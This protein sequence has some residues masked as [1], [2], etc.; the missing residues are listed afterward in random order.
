MVSWLKYSLNLLL[1]IGLLGACEQ[2]EDIKQS[3]DENLLNLQRK[4]YYQ[5]SKKRQVNSDQLIAINPNES[6]YYQ[7]KSMAHTKIGDYH[8]AF[9]LLEKAWDLD[10]KETGYYYG[11]LL[12][13]Y[14][15]DYERALDKLETYDNFTPDSPDFCWG[16]HINYLKGLCH[17]QMGNY[18][19]AISEFDRLIAYEGEFVDVY[20]YVYRGICQQKLNRHEAAIKDFDLA[21]Q[22][23]DNCS[24]AYF[25]KALSLQE[26]QSV[27]QAEQ[28]LLKS[29]ALVQEGYLKRHAYHEA[30]DGISLE[31]IEDHLSVLAQ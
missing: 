24:M 4:Q 18:E 10:A 17:K 25:Y 26:L 5:G 16:E 2:A 6:S 12:L 30:F 22:A 21:I 8:I 14:Y 7:G 29:K 23:Y 27:E 1:I 28:S 13:Y 3:Y 15:R 20:A 19:R 9:P 31:M 11:W